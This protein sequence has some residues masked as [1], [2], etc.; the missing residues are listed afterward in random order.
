MEQCLY[1]GEEQHQ[2]IVVG[3]AIMDIYHVVG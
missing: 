3:A 2:A 1:F